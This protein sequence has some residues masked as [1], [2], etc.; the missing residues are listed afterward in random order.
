MVDE[1]EQDYDCFYLVESTTRSMGS[2][3]ISS[4]GESPGTSSR[5]GTGST[6]GTSAESAAWTW[7][8]SRVLTST[9]TLPSSCSKVVHH[10]CLY[11]IRTPRIDNSVNGCCK[12]HKM[13]KLVS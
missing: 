9:D 1:V 2:T 7:C 8:P 5:T 13:L 10:S 4:P 6:A 3:T 11:G 12:R